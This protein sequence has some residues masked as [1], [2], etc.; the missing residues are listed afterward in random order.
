MAWTCDSWRSDAYDPS[1][2]GPR[3]EPVV[4]Y[5]GVTMYPA[6]FARTN[7]LAVYNEDEWSDLGLDDWA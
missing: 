5:N 7:P 3:V 2:D 4:T 1:V 6:W